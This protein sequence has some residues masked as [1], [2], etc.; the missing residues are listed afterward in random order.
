VPLQEKP[1]NPSQTQLL[2]QLCCRHAFSEIIMWIKK[3]AQELTSQR[4]SR[5]L[6]S[7]LC[8]LLALSFGC[9]FG[10][11]FFRFNLPLGARILALLAA[12]MVIFLQSRRAHELRIL[13]EVWICGQCN[14]VKR[15]DDQA[16]CL[17]GGR[18]ISM[19]E[20][21]WLENPAPTVCGSRDSKPAFP[22]PARGAA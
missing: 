9:I 18:F 10:L 7:S 15:H 13:S 22:I 17:C 16:T 14:R 21:K 8:A 1:W 6:A 20:M 12:A 3:S 19:P 2:R 4:R 11:S 5:R